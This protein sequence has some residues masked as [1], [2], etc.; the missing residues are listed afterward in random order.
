MWNHQ[1]L[2]FSVDTSAGFSSGKA[3][4]KNATMIV[5]FTAKLQIGQTV[6]SPWSPYLGLSKNRG[7]VDHKMAR[8]NE[9]HPLNLI[10][11]ES[12]SI[13]I[14]VVSVV[15]IYIYIFPCV[16]GFPCFSDQKQEGELSPPCTAPLPHP[17]LLHLGLWKAFFSPQENTVVLFNT[18]QK[19]TAFHG[20]QWISTHHGFYTWETTLFFNGCSWILQLKH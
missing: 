14:N 4:G 18:L 5:C 17:L 8:F 20:F 15:S 9:N 3:S 7:T 1:P 10:Q 19:I 11:F 16:D 13:N 6:P 2:N 12:V